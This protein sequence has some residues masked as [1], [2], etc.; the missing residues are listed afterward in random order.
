MKC[1][2]TSLLRMLK[3]METSYA[4]GILPT[5]VSGLETNYSVGS[6]DSPLR[7][8]VT[9]MEGEAF[10]CLLP[11]WRHLTESGTYG[12]PFFQPEWFN[13]FKTAFANRATP[14]LLTVW[15]GSTLKGIA[16]LQKTAHFFGRV[17]ARTIR[18]FSGIHSC[19]YDLIHDGLDEQHVVEALW[20]NL[21]ENRW[22][23][24]IEAEDVPHGGAF[25][26]LLECARRAGFLTGTWST[27]KSPYLFL[28]SPHEDP[29][30]NC[31]RTFKSLRGRLKSKLRKL[32]E[33]GEVSFGVGQGD[34]H[35]LFARFL[36]LESSGWKGS[37]GSAIVSSADATRFYALVTEYLKDVRCLRYYVLS[38]SG[39]AIAMHMGAVMNGVY[40]S[41]KVAYDES[42]AAFSP[43]QLLNQFVIK[44]LVQNGV[45]TF[46]FLG[47]R[48]LWKCV[49]APQVQEHSNCY[50]F[51][52][53]LKGR[54]LHALT[55]H[56]AGSIR[57]MRY[58]I[59][60]DPQDVRWGE[61]TVHT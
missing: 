12:A 14:H 25:H 58:R 33:Q 54:F 51:R 15:A 13:A 18:S 55:M 39:K 8:Q 45:R 6:A 1:I 56:G 11:Q 34:P 7:V 52:P 5:A 44:D 26:K 37:Q 2:K 46:D 50:I 22:W 4:D 43:G 38:V 24:V 3:H 49:W 28:P 41:P 16:P 23:D 32:A 20:D 19:R 10:A 40:Y 59:K 57:R 31:P 42:Y 27:R 47:A 9:P 30:A 48:S 53:S 61:K 21:R 35:E 29:F 17:P 36:S 60:G